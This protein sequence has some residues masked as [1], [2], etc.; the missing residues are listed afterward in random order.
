M[1]TATTYSAEKWPHV[2]RQAPC[3]ICEKPDW[4]VVSPDGAIAGCMRQQ[5]DKYFK[6]TPN[7]MHLH[8]LTDEPRERPAPRPQ[9]AAPPARDVMADR[10]VFAIVARSCAALPPVARDEMARRFGP[11]YGPQAAARFGIGYIDGPAL[12]AALV[13]ADRTQDAQHAG[14]LWRDGTVARSLEG[15][16]IIPHVRDGLIHDLRIAGIKGIHEETKET[17]LPGGY[18]DREIAD[19]FLNHDALNDLGPNKTIHLA[20]G[21]WKT[22]ALALAELPAIGT[23]GEAELSQGHVD[24]LHAAGVRT[25]ILH[26]DNENPKPGE[27]R[28][29]GRRLGLVKAER[30]VAAGFAVLIAEPP[31]EPGT[32]KVDPDALLRDLGPRAVRDYALSAIPLDAWRVVVGDVAA[33]DDAEPELVATL[34]ADVARLGDQ[35]RA[36][37]AELA[38]V[39]EERDFYRRCLDCP[40]PVIGRALPTIAE[41]LDRSYRAGA[42]HV[43]DGQEF[44]RLNLDRAERHGTVKRGA[45]TTAALRLAA[46][47]P[48]TTREVSVINPQGKKVTTNLHFLACPVEERTS[49]IRIGLGLLER[50]NAKNRHTG[51]KP[52]KVMPEAVAAQT[53]PVRRVEQTVE[54]FYSLRDKT[55]QAQPLAI[56]TAKPVIDYWTAEG[57]QLTRE[58]AQEWQIA[59]GV[60]APPVETQHHATGAG[61]GSRYVGNRPPTNPVEFQHQGT[62]VKSVETQQGSLPLDTPGICQDLD[63]GDQ[64]VIGGYCEPHYEQYSRRYDRAYADAFADAVEAQ[65]PV[66]TT[67]APPP[68]R[69]EIIDGPHGK[70]ERLWL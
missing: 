61:A 26:I 57:E 6:T 5:G 2:T 31:R 39:R 9:P 33:H 46:G 37:D 36:R 10:A 13:S 32:A 40:D 65:Q 44:A 28:S 60:I 20:G 52:P 53:D 21:S 56:V 3:A 15:R 25:I 68:F 17:S 30:L 16:L 24:A 59:H 22:I 1:M 41:E 48:H 23:R 47:T 38:A 58:A 66:P 18:A 69:S 45:I 14:V 63:C 11:V 12:A 7:G 8:R 62:N 35:L 34:R 19:L 27:E 42:A 4:C 67:P 50:A 54:T 43:E 51:R 49:A 55:T 64:A 70:I 29:A